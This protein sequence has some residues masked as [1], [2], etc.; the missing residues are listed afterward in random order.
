M[1]Y[2]LQENEHGFFE[3]VERSCRN[4]QHFL[5]VQPNDEPCQHALRGFCYLGDPGFKE[6]GSY[7]LYISC[8]GAKDCPAFIV[9]KR[10]S[11]LTAYERKLALSFNAYLEKEEPRMCRQV[12]KLN[13][14]MIEK[15]TTH[16]RKMRWVFGEFFKV[17]SN[18]AQ[19]WRSTNYKMLGFIHDNYDLKFAEYIQMLDAFTNFAKSYVEAHPSYAITNPTEPPVALNLTQDAR[20]KE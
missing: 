12:R 20:S 18:L 1:I 5:R 6:K 16:D 14:Q 13:K 7:H 19:E 11:D 17:R 8:S 10:K 9:D 2:A 3:N 15:E 4:C